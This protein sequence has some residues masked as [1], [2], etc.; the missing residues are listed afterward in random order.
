MKIQR[1]VFFFIQQN[2]YNLKIPNEHLYFGFMGNGSVGGAFKFCIYQSPNILLQYDRR[3]TG[4]V[5]DIITSLRSVKGRLKPTNR[6]HVR[7][8]VASLYNNPY[9]PRYA[10]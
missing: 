9:V 5:R 1:G 6:F 7:A 10:R 2:F 4:M 8:S 3:E